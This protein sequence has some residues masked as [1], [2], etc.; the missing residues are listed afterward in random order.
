M[1][2]RLELHGAV[3]W[4]VKSFCGRQDARRPHSQDGC[5]PSRRAS[6]FRK[7]IEDEVEE[8]DED[9]FG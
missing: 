9:D 3:C 6:G 4:W 1:T 5:A 2:R 8:D 7:N